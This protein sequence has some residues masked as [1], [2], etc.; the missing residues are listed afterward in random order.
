MIF[1]SMSRKE[2]LR[3]LADP[4]RRWSLLMLS[5]ATSIDALAVGLSLALINVE[6]ISASVIIGIVAAGMTLV[7]LFSGRKLGEKFGKKMELL[8]GLILI[9]IGTKI[10]IDHLSA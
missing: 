8:G 2:E 7:G 10:L 6:I 3:T 5:I 9:G 4:T 1:E